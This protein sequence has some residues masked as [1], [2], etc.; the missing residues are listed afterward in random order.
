MQRKSI[1]IAGVIWTLFYASFIVWI[2]A[3]EPRSF[4]EI[5][6]N[7]QVAVGTYE[8]NEEK[9]SNGL[10]LFR[11]DQF[12]AARDE[13]A[14]AHSFPLPLPSTAKAGVVSTTIGRFSMMG[15]RQSIAQSTLVLAARWWLMIQICK[16]TRRLN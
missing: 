1:Q 15:W 11:R 7:T 8:I 4:N 13:W 12:R 6:A 14:A 3:T 5:A 16:C 2:Y 9:F 10:T